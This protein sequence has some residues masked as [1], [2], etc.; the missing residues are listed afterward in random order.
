MVCRLPV[1]H[2]PLVLWF[3][4]APYC[5]YH[6]RRHYCFTTIIISTPSSCATAILLSQTL[7]DHSLTL[8][9]RFLYSR[10]TQPPPS[11]PRETNRPPSSIRPAPFPEPPDPIAHPAM[12][13]PHIDIIPSPSPS[14]RRP[15]KDTPN[16]L[17][18]DSSTKAPSTSYVSF[19]PKII[20]RAPPSSPRRSS[21]PPSHR[22][23]A[24]QCDR[25][26][27]VEFLGGF[28]AR[29]DALAREQ[30]RFKEE[31]SRAEESARDVVL[32]PPT[33]A[34]PPPASAPA[35]APAQPPQPT[36]RP[37]FVYVQR[38]R[39]GYRRRSPSSSDDSS[40]SRYSLRAL[41]GRVALLWDRVD[42][43]DLWRDREV[44]RRERSWERRMPWG[45]GEVGARGRG[46][47]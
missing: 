43:L 30:E 12:C 20:Y 27:E 10:S 21:V 19:S 44:R 37:P 18:G 25:S 5:L 8:S 32:P 36:P 31:K 3:F 47:W 40:V 15:R 9:R 22:P 29:R 6:H 33:P 16:S 14:R 42:A 11:P 23:S 41:R 7:R 45:L 1:A 24:P 34:P 39:P 26:P 28:L 35:P 38:P 4:S 13:I 46:R 17:S 2:H